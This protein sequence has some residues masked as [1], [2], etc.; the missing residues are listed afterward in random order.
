[1]V[2]K[3]NLSTTLR[4]QKEL[5]VEKKIWQNEIITKYSE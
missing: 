2:E 5:K 4:V 3:G 1:M